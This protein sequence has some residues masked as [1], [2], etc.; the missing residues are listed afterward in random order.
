MTNFF[1][2]TCCRWNASLNKIGLSTLDWMIFSFIATSFAWLE[3]SC[4]FT[5]MSIKVASKDRQS[6]IACC[7]RIGMMQKRHSCARFVVEL[8]MKFRSSKSSS[9]RPFWPKYHYVPPTRNDIT[10]PYF[11]WST[12]F[13]R[14]F[15]P[16]L[17]M[18]TEVRSSLWS[19]PRMR[20]NDRSIDR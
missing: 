7:E 20:M 12:F 15:S 4:P 18:T 10:A 14:R 5:A 11:N 9:L 17:P 16:S 8:C 3:R 2:R 6:A 13:P 1:D 19:P